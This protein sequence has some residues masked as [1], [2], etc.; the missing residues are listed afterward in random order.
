MKKN[1]TLFIIYCLFIG[2]LS[3]LSA[4][5]QYFQNVKISKN[6]NFTTAKDIYTKN[7]SIQWENYDFTIEPVISNT[8]F[9][10]SFD[11]KN[12]NDFDRQYLFFNTIW[13]KKVF[14][15]YKINDSIYIEKSGIA[16]KPSEKSLKTF[17]TNVPLPIN[18]EISKCYLYLESNYGYWL[19]LIIYSSHNIIN[20]NLTVSSRESFYYGFII[21]ALLSSLVFY[22]YLKERIY[23]YYTLFTSS[24]L[25]N[26]TIDNGHIYQILPFLNTQENIS[27]TFSLYTIGTALFTISII[28]YFIEYFNL[29]TELPQYLKYIYF[30]II[31]RVLMVFFELSKKSIFID[32]KDISFVIFCFLLFISIRLFNKHKVM[33]SFAIFSLL[34]FTSG[35]V[36]HKFEIDYSET[37]TSYLIFLNIS[38]FEII[39][40][41][42]SVSY[43]HNFLKNQYLKTVSILLEETEKSKKITEELNKEL[44][45]KVADRTQEIKHQMEEISRLN[46]LLKKDNLQLEH[47]VEDITTA[48]A[49]QENLLFADFCKI[50]PSEDNCFKY[51]A[52]LKWNEKRPY[53]C[54]KCGYKGYKEREQYARRCSKCNYIESA[55][56]STLFHKLKFPIQKAF[57]ITYITCT[58]N[59]NAPIENLS[60][61]IDLRIGTYWKFQKRVQDIIAIIKTKQKRKP[62][63]WTQ[64][65]E[66]SIENDIFSQSDDI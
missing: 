38:S 29:K 64:L 49:F 4:Q 59:K 20:Y 43:R 31:L 60:N 48:R 22:V 30:L 34:L 13:F 3:Q 37:L 51:V 17:I 6:Y 56:S 47:E 15:I 25:I 19:P 62:F 54:K 2:K 61:E 55:I 21:L 36:I 46:E 14:I 8:K 26:R 40:F 35:L 5:D 52:D 53:Y 10:I 39:I 63:T 16:V 41:F 66:Y 45:I 50:F 7:D 42:I 9:L 11:Y 27:F 58:G 44:E 24:I 12:I 23:I 1:L 18:N 33:S 57:Y 28:L 65:I 32:S